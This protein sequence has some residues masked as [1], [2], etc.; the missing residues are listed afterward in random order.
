M[1]S[2][3]QVGCNFAGCT[4]S[5]PPAI[6]GISVAAFIATQPYGVTV[7][8]GQTAT[9]SVIAAGSTPLTIQWQ[10]NRANIAGATS[11][12]YTTPPTTSGDNGVVF[13]VLVSNSIGSITSTSASLT[14]N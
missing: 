11:S 5:G 2:S 10:K 4:S 8:A 7:S 6:S 12:S 13:T 1:N 3:V 14:V 9:F